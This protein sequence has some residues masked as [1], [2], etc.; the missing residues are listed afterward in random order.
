MRLGLIFALI[1]VVGTE[2]IATE[3]GLGQARVY[4]QSTFNIDSIMV[5]LIVLASVGPTVTV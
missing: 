3:R 4:L 2:L 5:I 1:G